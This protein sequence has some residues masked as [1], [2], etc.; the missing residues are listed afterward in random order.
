MLSSSIS[1]RS[2]SSVLM[3]DTG[4]VSL[5]DGW[6]RL[7][8]L[9][10]SYVRSEVEPWYPPA[11]LQHH[12]DDLTHGLTDP[13]LPPTGSAEPTQP[14]CTSRPPSPQVGEDDRLA[15]ILMSQLTPS[16]RALPTS[17]VASDTILNYDH[18]TIQRFKFP[19]STFKSCKS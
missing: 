5:V 3:D 15:Y 18:H 14:S 17:K 7:H 9:I 16:S 4:S 1:S 6:L 12:L 8:N 10:L 13:N 2:L 11:P 19:R